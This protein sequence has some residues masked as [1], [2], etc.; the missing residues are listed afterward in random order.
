VENGDERLAC[1]RVDARAEDAIVL[2]VLSSGLD[3]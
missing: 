2:F 3:E 1:P